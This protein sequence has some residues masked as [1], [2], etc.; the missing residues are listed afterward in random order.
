MFHINMDDKMLKNHDGNFRVMIN[1]LHIPN[2]HARKKN[3]TVNTVDFSGLCS[4]QQ[5]FF[6][7]LDRTSFPSL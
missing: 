5:F 2:Y 6:T 1:R 4:D 3:G 7:L